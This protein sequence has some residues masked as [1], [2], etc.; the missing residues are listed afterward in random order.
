[1]TLETDKIESDINRSRHA[2]NDT[3]EALGGKLTPGQMVD[4]AMG[5]LQGQAGKFTTNIGRQV[6]DNPIPVLLMAAG[7]VL[8]VMNKSKSASD[9]APDTDSSHE[10]RDGALEAA[11]S[12]LVRRHDESDHDWSHRQHETDAGALGLKQHVGEA[13]DA[14]KSR[15]SEMAASVGNTLDGLKEGAAGG[16]GHATQALMDGT[17]SARSFA[18]DQ[19]RNAK[20]IAGDLKHK[21]G[22][23]F[24]DNPLAVA[25]VGMAIGAVIGGATTLSRI[26]RKNLHGVADAAGR[27]GA[28]LAEQGAQAVHALVDAKQASVT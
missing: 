27:A 19:T 10:E 28:N 21:A 6:R 11:R 18:A 5:L 7:A 4:E 3:I 25:A 1:M 15:V 9:A 23:F 12:S 16:Y 13:I 14:F 22:D 20:H 24:D 26:E 2:L 8:L 17:N